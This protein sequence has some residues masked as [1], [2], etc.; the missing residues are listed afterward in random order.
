[1]PMLW[2]QSTIPGVALNRL[3]ESRKRCVRDFDFQN[4][5]K[6]ASWPRMYRTVF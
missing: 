4:R 1:M 6:N 3:D 5:N 2:L